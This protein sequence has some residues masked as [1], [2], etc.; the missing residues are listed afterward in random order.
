MYSTVKTVM[1]THNP[2][3]GDVQALLEYLF[4]TEERRTILEK[5]REGLT[6][7]HGGVPNT[8][9]YLPKEDPGWDPNTSGGLQ[10]VKEYQ[11]LILYGIQHGVQKPKNLSKLYEV[12][13]GDKETPSAFYERLC[14]V[15]RKWTDLDP[16]H[17]S[18]SKLFNMLFIGQAAADIRKK[19]QKVEGADGMTISRLLSIAYK[20]YKVSPADPLVPVK[21]GNEIIDF[22]TD[23]G[24]THSVVTSCRGPLSGTKISVVGATG[25]KTLKPFLQPMEC[26]IGNTK[27]T[28]EFLYMPECPLPLL[29]QDL[30]CKP[31]AQLTFSEDSVQL[32][33]PPE[34]AWKAQICLLTEKD[35]NEEMNISEEVL[36]AVIPLVWASKIPGRAK[37]ATPVKIELKPGA[38]PVRKK[39]YPIKLEA[40]K[41]SEPII[42]SFLEHGLLRECQSELNTPILPVKKPHSSEYRLVQDLREINA[43]TVDVHPV[44]PNPY[45]LLTTIPNSNT[46]FTVLD[47]KDAAFCIPVDEQSQTIFAFEWENP[48]T[49]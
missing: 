37:N 49:G 42:S 22:V 33:I 16:E 39:Q 35:P 34:T 15:A 28:H 31:N 14:E 20:V 9:M 30:L 29:G 3:W 21:L 1:M 40:R 44:V 2:N 13:Q 45:T 11:K 46:Y 12:R 6:Q 7:E 24:A 48:T 8:N 47:L 25:K 10:R 17:D 4:T 41:G 38:Q 19:L 27:L 43:R 5:A 18:N 32:H 26:S 36:N 23:S